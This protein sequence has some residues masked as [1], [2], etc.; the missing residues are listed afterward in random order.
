MVSSDRPWPPTEAE[1]TDDLAKVL[2]VRVGYPLRGKATTET[3][4]A[5][6]AR[7]SD[8][9]TLPSLRQVADAV[10]ASIGRLAP[11]S[12]AK[13]TA[14]V[15]GVDPD[16]AD[17]RTAAERRRAAAITLKV[18]VSALK[19]DIE[20]R[21]CILIADDLLK[22]LPADSLPPE[23][24]DK[25]QQTA[26]EPV[27][28]GLTTGQERS[29]WQPLRRKSA[30]AGFVLLLMIAVTLLAT[31]PWDEA[32]A[33]TDVE[34][35]RLTAEAERPLDLSQTPL[36]GE[37]SSVLG[38]GDEIGGRRIYQYVNVTPVPNYP[39]LDSFIDSTEH[40]G[41]ERM[42]LRVGTGPA[43]YARHHP[44]S[45]TPA[46]AAQANNLVYIWI[47]VANDAPEQSDCSKLVGPTIA[48]N[49]RVR[50]TIWNSPS[51][52][53]HI[54]R[55][56]ISADNAY[57]KWITDTA[58]VITSKAMPLSFDPEDSWQYSITPGQFAHEA[59]L[60]NQDFFDAGGMELSSDGLLGSCWA[61]RWAFHLAFHQ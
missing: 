59:P 20:H 45:F 16:T 41:D 17:M 7:L 46:V 35:A 22:R 40:I 33:T 19:E 57:P 3:L 34:L 54:V 48:T 61:N 37:T 24:Y 47:Y 6:A 23:G 21:M 38:F 15:F 43:W 25:S 11:G 42:F 18:E 1:L 51:N 5:V 13:A 10:T 28:A 2:T 26:D 4:N 32:R 31:K 30:L 55:G 58:A 60:P 9:P 53:L 49:T 52:H 12:F 8:D 29:S 56:W 50:L 44:V 39:I 36:P 27:S 14:Q